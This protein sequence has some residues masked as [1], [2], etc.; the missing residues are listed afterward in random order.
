MKAKI[1]KLLR[2]FSTALVI[3]SLILFTVSIS[4]AAG[5]SKVVK[6]RGDGAYFDAWTPGGGEFVLLVSRDSV[7]NT[8]Y[9]NYTCFDHGWNV[10][11]SGDG[12]IPN[13]DLSG[14]WK[15]GMSLRT[16]TSRLANASGLAGTI[17]IDWSTCNGL[18]SQVSGSQAYATGYNNEII[19][20]TS[21]IWD[22]CVT[23]ATSNIL[24]MT[25]N[26]NFATAS[27]STNTMIELQS[28]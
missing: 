22:Q 24:S 6:A 15:Q 8:T 12:N 10:I 21:G 3:G 5:N 17:S 9:I 2:P 27:F 14:Q 19:Q 16:S 4:I 26:P 25:L 11:A 23:S 20:R 13:E 18:L 1:N 28:H 7:N